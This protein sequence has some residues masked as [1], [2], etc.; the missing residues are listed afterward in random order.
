MIVYDDKWD[1]M[2][3]ALELFK[4]NDEIYVAVL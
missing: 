1:N 2:I 4:H 3:G